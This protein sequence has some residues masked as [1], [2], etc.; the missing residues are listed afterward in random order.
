[1]TTTV[2]FEGNGSGGGS[3]TATVSLAVEG[4]VTASPRDYKWAG[5]ST[6]EQGQSVAFLAQW[7]YGRALAAATRSHATGVSGEGGAAG[8]KTVVT[9]SSDDLPTVTVTLDGFTSVADAR[10]QAKRVI[11]DLVRSLVPPDDQDH[12]RR[13]LNAIVLPGGL[14]DWAEPLY[15]TAPS[16]P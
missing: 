5:V 1:M 7:A 13:A 6:A 11:D 15:R 9:W 10:G 14:E 12:R 4:A 2:V 3:Q 8:W 16:Y